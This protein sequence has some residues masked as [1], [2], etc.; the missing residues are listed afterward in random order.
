M[1]KLLL[2][3]IP[4]LLASPVALA[5][6]PGELTG[7]YSAQHSEKEAGETVR[8]PSTIR[9]KKLK[10]GN[11]E[12]VEKSTARSPVRFSA[13]HVFTK[14]GKFTSRLTQEGFKGVSSYSG[15]WRSAGDDIAITAKGTDG[16]LSA[17]IFTT[18]TGFTFSGNLAKSQITIKAKK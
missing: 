8:V 10:N 18:K 11:V 5:L 13:T 16:K 15:T 2:A 6:K 14:K 3:V 1:K 7:V 17:K 9:V 12:F 4:L